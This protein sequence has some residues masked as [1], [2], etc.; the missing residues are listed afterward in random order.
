MERPVYLDPAFDSLILLSELQIL[1]DMADRV[2][3]STAHDIAAITS[4][5]ELEPDYIWRQIHS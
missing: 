4:R 1:G 5:D 3:L 2:F